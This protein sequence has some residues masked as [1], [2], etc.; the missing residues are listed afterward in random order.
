MIKSAY[1]RRIYCLKSYQKH[2]K[3]VKIHDFLAGGH[4]LAVCSKV[5]IHTVSWTIS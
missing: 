2:S 3:S 4:S 1:S 5:K